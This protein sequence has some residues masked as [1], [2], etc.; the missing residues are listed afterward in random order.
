MKI[1]T[2]MLVV[3]V[4]F[5]GFFFLQ[6]RIFPVTQP[7]FFL[8][9][10][11]LAYFEQK[12]GVAALDQ[13]KASR[14]GKACS[15]LDLPG[16]LQQIGAS[17]AQVK[18]VEKFLQS[19][20]EFQGNALVRELLGSQFSLALL[21][22]RS[23]T[24]KDP[25]AKKL[26]RQ[27]VLICKPQH[28]A[29]ALDLISTYYT[30]DTKV[31]VVSYGS[32]SIK[33]YESNGDVFFVAVI[34]KNIIASFEERA[35]RECIDSFD[36][37]ENSLAHTKLYQRNATM[38][39]GAERMAYISFDQ[40][41]TFA[42]NEIGKSHLAEKD[43]L[44]GELKE[45]SGTVSLGYGGWRNQ[46]SV[47]DKLIVYTKP[48]DAN[49]HLQKMLAIPLEKNESLHLLAEDMLMYYWTNTF[50]LSM[51]W[52]MFLG[53]EQKNPSTVKA[54]RSG[55]KEVTGMQAEEILAMIDTGIHFFIEQGA[56]NQFLPFPDLAF[57]LKLK[58]PHEFENFL[59]NLLLRN[60]VSLTK[61]NYE[62]LTYHYW[63]TY[64]AKNFQPLYAVHEGKLY[65]A[66][67]VDMLKKIIDG[68]AANVKL[69]SSQHLADFDPGFTQPNNALW[70]SNQA[71]LVNML[72]DLISW[73]GT[74]LALKDKTLSAKSKVIIDKLINPLLDG[75]AMYEQA[76]TRSY[77]DK[78]M[79][80]VESKTRIAQ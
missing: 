49:P 33:R 54:V 45:M 25:F 53:E 35:V 58:K 78:D 68:P 12:N 55:I 51:L 27:L 39:A 40:I 38:L 59:E 66:S 21:P 2:G 46:T 9:A 31:S 15:S 76:A 42:K 8:P 28:S 7:A 79:I 70:Y 37:K 80:I 67:N 56:E 29:K 69:L 23:W 13:F 52:K 5:L 17:P 57:I 18:D 19:V 14:L 34:E 3:V 44:L 26:Q 71:K 16:T 43:Q 73:G 32:H 74:M 22:E 10:D 60:G 61:E 20:K 50:D 1:V 77:T 48:E 41:R 64:P 47:E 24:E 72:Q 4:L 62:G 11:T 63:G 36:K 30:G 65:I 75:C 6:D